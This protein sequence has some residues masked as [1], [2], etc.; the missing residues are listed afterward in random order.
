MQLDETTKDLMAEVGN[1]SI[2]WGSNKIAEYS[3]QIVDIKLVTAKTYKQDAMLELLKPQ[4]QELRVSGEIIGDID[5]RVFFCIKNKDLELIKEYFPKLDT[6]KNSNSKAEQG[7]ELIKIFAKGFAHGMSAMTGLEV[8]ANDNLD[9]VDS[10]NLDNIP[11]DNISF[12]SAIIIKQKTLNFEV[13]FASDA[14]III[15]K[16]ASAMGLC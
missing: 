6:V 12:E 8:L 16:V 9:P 2:G 7:F 11:E 1:I 5:G 10:N 13:I 4:E 14:N 15:K 3:D